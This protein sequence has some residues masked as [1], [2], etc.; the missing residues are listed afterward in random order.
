MKILAIQ[1]S[2]RPEKSNTEMILQEFLKGAESRG[3]ECETIYLKEKRINPCTGCNTCWIKTPG[4]CIVNDDMI[5]LLYR[6]RECDILV[7]ATPLY[8]YNITSLLKAFQERLHPLIDPH[9]VKDGELYRHPRRFEKPRYMVLIS[10]CGL[11][12]VCH[13][14]GL[15][16]IFRQI[17]W[18]N[19]IRLVGE[20]LM[21]AAD[22]LKKENLR[23]TL[24]IN[25]QASYRAGIEV[26]SEGKVSK[27][28]E[29]QIL[30]S[31]L[32]PDEMAEMANC[33][34]DTHIKRI[35]R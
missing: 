17:E 29:D 27:K 4:V 13:F 33:W 15:R 32:T 6:V 30:K 14:E 16:Q 34:W 10:T 5:D 1:G 23:E 21:P 12:N 11:P 3:A 24:S 2:H 35:D 9:L 25:L 19:Q 18:S 26:V 28:V 8:N 7:Y 31:P 20:L 22:L